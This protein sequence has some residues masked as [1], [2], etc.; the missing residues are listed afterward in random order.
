MN[1]TPHWRSISDLPV[2]ASLL[3]IMLYEDEGQYR[4][5][6]EC[7]PRPYVLDDETVERV[8]QDFSEQ[9]ADLSLFRQQLSHWLEGDLTASEQQEVERLQG[10][11]AKLRE[12]A[13]SVLSLAEELKQGTIER[14]LSK[15]DG[16]LGLEFLLG[17]RKL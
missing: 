12:L 5:L 8:I 1:Q 10:C 15:G 14:V 2:V 17:K 9:K 16:E 3:E 11:V 6:R 4:T 13:E 7:R